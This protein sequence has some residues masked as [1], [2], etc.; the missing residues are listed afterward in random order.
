M[1]PFNDLNRTNFMVDLMCYYVATDPTAEQSVLSVLPL[2]C[3][4]ILY[5]PIPAEKNDT[6]STIKLKPQFRA[7]K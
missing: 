2:D 5:Q 3:E 6:A 7:Y 1:L 4:V